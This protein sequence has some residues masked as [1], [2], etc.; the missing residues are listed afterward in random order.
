MTEIRL[1]RQEGHVFGSDRS[2]GNPMA[3]ER[4]DKP[5]RAFHVEATFD[6]LGRAPKRARDLGKN[7]VSPCKA[8]S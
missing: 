5:P 4:R 8:A 1:D 6:E 2:P 7:A 3:R